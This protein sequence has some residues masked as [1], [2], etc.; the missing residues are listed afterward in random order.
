M[1]SKSDLANGI[2][3]NPDHFRDVSELERRTAFSFQS[4][5]WI[6]DLGIEHLSGD[7]ISELQQAKLR[8]LELRR[9]NNPDDP[10]QMTLI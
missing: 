7:E 4:A 10:M 9:L 2:A 8:N 5:Q 3:W 1:A 6:S